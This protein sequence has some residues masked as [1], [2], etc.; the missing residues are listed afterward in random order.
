MQPKF[1]WTVCECGVSI[2]VLYEDLV[3]CHDID[4]RFGTVSVRACSVPLVF[5]KIDIFDL[6][7]AAKCCIETR[8]RITETRFEYI[9]TI[10]SIL[11]V[12]ASSDT[13]KRHHS[14]RI[15]V[16]ASIF[17][18]TVQFNFIFLSPST[19]KEAQ[20]NNEKESNYLFPYR[21]GNWKIKKSDSQSLP[22]ACLDHTWLPRINHKNILLMPPRLRR[23]SP[24][25]EEFVF[26]SRRVHI[27]FPRYQQTRLHPCERNGT[28]TNCMVHSGVPACKT[29][30]IIYIAKT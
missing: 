17:Q 19:E 27:P 11:H 4:E 14:H 2:H 28:T 12:P 25:Q 8:S 3:S 10:D 9:R 23:H 15:D 18:C 1:T 13:R 20:W 24:K 30:N 21:S 29:N 7:G 26:V 6:N 5:G 16:L 22:F